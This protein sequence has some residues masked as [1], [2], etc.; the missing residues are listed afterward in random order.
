MNWIIKKIIGSKHERD[1]KK[2]APMVEKINALDESFK[3]LSDADLK[4]KTTEF[5]Q[6]LEGEAHSMTLNLKPLL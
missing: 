6:R 2:L 4:A 1:L 3:A 5:K